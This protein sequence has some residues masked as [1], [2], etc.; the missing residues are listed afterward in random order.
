[1]FF[2]FLLKIVETCLLSQRIS[3]KLSSRLEWPDKMYYDKKMIKFFL[4]LIYL[5]LKKSGA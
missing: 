2:D 3:R 1:M 5:K 4:R